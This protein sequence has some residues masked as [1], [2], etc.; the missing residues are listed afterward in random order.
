M[1]FS[2]SQISKWGQDYEKELCAKFD[3]IADRLSLEI[4]SGTGEYEL[5]NYV[6]NIRSVLYK[7]KEL[8]PKGGRSSILTGD[9][10]FAT[11]MS[12]P[13]EYQV[14]GMGLRV[15][16]LLPTPGDNIPVYTPIDARAGL[17]TVEADR[18]A[19]IVEFYRTPHPRL[20]DETLML[21]RWFRRYVLKD[22]ICWKAF[23]SEGPQQDLKAAGYY[24]EKRNV[25]EGY[26]SDI[27]SSMYRSYQRVL[28]DNKQ[29]GRRKP[30]HP[31]LPPN[32]GYPTYG[33]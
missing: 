14:S 12:A 22:Y 30:G 11:S 15:L 3:F 20:L 23:T 27:K 6:T 13:Y 32:F 18:D 4:I 28:S 7:G 9:I 25:N 21:P 10:P 26:C 24:E 19:C 2:D 16:R 29:I 8:H 17:W 5:P 1:A 33:G 31:V